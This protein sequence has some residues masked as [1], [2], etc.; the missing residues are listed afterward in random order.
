MAT[1]QGK[2]DAKHFA[3]CCADQNSSS[4]NH[5]TTWLTRDVYCFS[6]DNWRLAF[7]GPTC[8]VVLR[9]CQQWSLRPVGCM[10]ISLWF[11][12]N[13]KI[14]D[15][16]TYPALQTTLISVLS[17][18]AAKIHAAVYRPC[19]TPLRQR[20]SRTQCTTWDGLVIIAVEL[21][22]YFI[23]IV[24]G[25]AAWSSDVFGDESFFKLSFFNCLVRSIDD[26]R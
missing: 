4:D 8:R 10:E 20:P 22:L 16:F 19:G 9:A 21:K 26:C 24:V 7:Q 2:E 5:W 23:S 14:L 3:F 17:K 25:I 6:L 11:C 12:P 15:H 13:I 1:V 18:D